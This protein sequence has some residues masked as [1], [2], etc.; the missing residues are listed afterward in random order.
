MVKI[1]KTELLRSLV[2]FEVVFVVI[3]VAVFWTFAG[4]L[5]LFTDSVQMLLNLSCALLSFRIYFIL[6]GFIASGLFERAVIGFYLKGLAGWIF[7]VF[8]YSLVAFTLALVPSLY[9]PSNK[10]ETSNIE[11]ISAQDGRESLPK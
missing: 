9:R 5:A 11:H 6:P 8:V 7:S 3:P 10:S 4:I 2:L 1:D